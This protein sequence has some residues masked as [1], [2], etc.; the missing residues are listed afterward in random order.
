MLNIYHLVCE[1]IGTTSNWGTRVLTLYVVY[2]QWADNDTKVPGAL[3]LIVVCLTRRNERHLVILKK[4]RP[5]NVKKKRVIIQVQS[6]ITKCLSFCRET[7]HLNNPFQKKSS[8]QRALVFFLSKVSISIQILSDILP[9]VKTTFGVILTREPRVPSFAV[10][11]KHL[12]IVTKCG[13]SFPADADAGKGL[14]CLV[15]EILEFIQID[16]YYN[17]SDSVVEN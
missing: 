14:S 13:T 6:F 4:S 7:L 2:L 16:I 8:V 1:N 3:L 17:I 10:V 12:G 15:L 5:S 9:A 11:P